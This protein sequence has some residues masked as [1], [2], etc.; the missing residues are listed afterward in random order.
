MATL[1]PGD[2]KTELNLNGTWTD[3]SHYTFNTADS[4][5]VNITRGI[6]DES[7][8]ANAA[9]LA[10]QLSNA[11]G[12]FSARNPT[13]P[14]WP[15]LVRNTQMRVSVPEGKSYLRIEVDNSASS[16]ASCPDAAGLDITGDTEVQIDVTLDN[17]N[18]AGS[19]GLCSKW[20]A[21][22]NQRSWILYL[23]E[24]GTLAFAWS[25]LGTAVDGLAISTVAVPIPGLRRMAIKATLATGTGTVTFYTAQPVANQASVGSILSNSPVWVQL[26][27]AVVVGANTV[28]NSTATIRLGN[29]LTS[30]VSGI[31]GCFGKVHAFNLL[32]GIGGTTKASPDFTAQTAGAASFADAQSNTWTVNG[33]AEI[34]NRRYRFHGEVAAWPQTWDPSGVVVWA[35]ITA[36]G[37]LRRLGQSNKPLRSA[38]YRYWNK[39][40]TVTPV[41]YWS[42]EEGSKAQG[43]ASP[44]A[45]INPMVINSGTPGFLTDTSFA[46]STALPTINGASWYGAV[47]VYTV[48]TDHQVTA[49][50][51]IPSTPDTDNTIPLAVQTSGT[52]SLLTVRYQQASTG[53]L[54]LQCW[55]DAGALLSVSPTAFTGVNGQ[56][57]AVRIAVGSPSG[58]NSTV[59]FSILQPGFATASTG[60]DTVPATL[61]GRVTSVEVQLPTFTGNL[62][63]TIAIGHIAVTAAN[64][65]LSNWTGQVQPLN[66]WQG[67]A[68]GTRFARLCSEEGLGFR[69]M[70]Q[71]SVSTVMGSQLSATLI[72]LLQDCANVDR[73]MMFEPRQ[74]LALG[75]RTRYSLSNQSAAVTLT[76]TSAH[77]SGTLQETEDDQFL[78]NDVSVQRVGGNSRR[79]VLTTGAMSTLA[80]PSGVGVYDTQVTIN[81]LSDWQCRD[82]AGWLLWLGTTSEPR[83]PLIQLS[84]TRTALSSI[85]YDLQEMDQGDFLQ[86]NLSTTVTPWLSPDGISVLLNQTV[87]RL[88]DYIYEIDLVG[89]PEQP[90]ETAVLGSQAYL[91]DTDA[92]TL[93][94]NVNTTQTLM[95]VNTTA[96]SNFPLWTTAA[97]DF[98]FD[99]KT[100]GERMTV[101]D[102]NGPPGTFLTGDNGTFDSTLG[103]WTNNTNCAISQ[104]GS[105]AH[106]GTG[107][108]QMSSSAA[109]NMTAGSCTA[110]NILTQGMACAANDVI[111]LAAWFRAAAS[112]RTCAVGAQFFTSGGVSISTLFSANTITDATGSYTKCSGTVTAP[113][114]SAFCR[115]V[116]QVQ[117]TAAASEIHYVDDAYMGDQ[118]S[119]SASNQTFVVVRS[120][121]GVVTSPAS[122]SDVRLFNPPV[123]AM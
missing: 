28:F 59:T 109:G 60:T 85:Y 6:P 12:R 16:G 35:S 110:G 115:M 97:G 5:G 10:A 14:Y 75:Y 123:L 121:N 82:E 114:T 54:T 102:I 65:A 53:T 34:S 101:R 66:A 103:N 107:A 84:L 43:F 3:I 111:G 95:R 9:A 92:S 68:A 39:T 22:G 73:G 104:V 38:M 90:Y 83:Y 44:I 119:G 37:L 89:V 17:W 118:T 56:Q 67:E 79:Q 15:N 117:S 49:L 2:L 72:S 70:G 78:V 45:G 69:G 29:A 8:I 21:S 116:P 19:Q 47:P 120:I 71:M 57:L 87:E 50:L 61:L 42:L 46:C 52:I 1:Q 122:G 106:A 100:A 77:L 81:V 64:F 94:A 33:T 51:D 98:P 93:A 4:P 40:P 63:K 41:A 112:P 91:V 58:G 62:A 86:V 88:H 25:H 24:N 11:D 30:D 108:M 31:T 23:Q 55:N 96:G 18:S 74:A 113:A 20:T 76:Y 7:P 99:I 80:P 26:G 32:S 36:N 105:P 13:G 27:S 48:G